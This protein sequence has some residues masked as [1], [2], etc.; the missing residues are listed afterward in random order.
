MFKIILGI[1]FVFLFIVSP[2]FRCIILNPIKTIVNGIKDI[3]FYFK[4][5]KYNEAPYGKIVG[6]IADDS[7]AFGCGKTLSTVEY[8][9][10]LYKKYNNKQ[11]WC[12]RRK[13]FVTQKITVISNI[14][15]KTIPYISF[16][17]F[18]QYVSYLK[19]RYTK[20]MEEDII[21]VTIG[22]I[23]EA[24]S[25][26]NS[27]SFKT[28]FSATTIA[29]LLTSRHYRSMLCYTTQRYNLVDCL[30]R[31]VTSY[32]ISCNKLWRLQRLNFYDAYELEN[33]PNPTLVQPYK[34][35]CWFVTNE[36]FAKYNT[37]ALLED[38]EKKCDANDM[39]SESEVLESLQMPQTNIDGIMNVS[40]KYKRKHKK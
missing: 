36:T 17:S 34:K 6:Y 1:I 24:S 31:N 10:E 8:I 5:K 38:I 9:T 16:K 2:T 27:R 4:H 32:C 15:L 7:K 25:I 40:K 3:Y 13:K 12:S 14:S 30:L 35:G 29:T 18:K 39:M 19:E 33:S 11:I 21:T 37:F 28:N 20:D 23:D 22:I 26:L